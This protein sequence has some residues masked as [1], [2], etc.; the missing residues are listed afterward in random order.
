MIEEVTPA[1]G[2]FTQ[3]ARSSSSSGLASSL[4]RT[5]CPGRGVF[6]VAQS[7]LASVRESRPSRAAHTTSLDYP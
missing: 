1:Q 7:A 4:H 6:T 3:A 2:V 5:S